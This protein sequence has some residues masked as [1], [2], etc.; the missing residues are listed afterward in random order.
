MT[1]RFTSIHRTSDGDTV[2]ALVE[3]Y[4]LSSERALLEIEPNAA[5][6]ERL[7]A[8][9]ALPAGLTVHIPPNAVDLV[10]QR[11]YRLHEIRPVLLSHF[12]TMLEIAETDLRPVLEASSSPVDSEEGFD[13]LARLAEYVAESVSTIAANTRPLVDLAV[14]MSLTHVATDMDRAAA[15]AASDPRCGLYWT[16]TPLI[17]EQWEA[18]WHPELWRARWG[19][20]GA[21]DPWG[22]ASQYKVTIRSIVVQQVDTR[23]REAQALERELRNEE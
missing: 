20:A 8:G 16:I 15:N 6:R 5:I 22:S 18:M 11:Q 1:I 14:G 17:L 21:D 13:V 4:R 3:Q 7:Q 12:D 10:R 2:D 23:I 9:G 19:G